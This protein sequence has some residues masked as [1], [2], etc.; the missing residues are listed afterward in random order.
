MLPQLLGAVLSGEASAT[1]KRLKTQVV[2]FSV[3]GI[4]ALLG[5]FFL[6]IAGYLYA[7]QHLGALP[8]ALWFAGVLLGIAL[9]GYIIYRVSA[10]AR[11]RR[12]ARRRRSELTGVAAATALAALPALAS[13]GG[14]GLVLTPI[15]AAVGYQIYKE[16]T[17]SSKRLDR[18]E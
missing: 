14:A 13:R 16:N 11:A 1:V 7:A 10:G 12:A 3:L 5:L 8:A 6:L 17:R 4:F 2:V 18:A 9:L 15:L